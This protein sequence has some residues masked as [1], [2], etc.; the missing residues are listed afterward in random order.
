MTLF[1]WVCVFWGFQKLSNSSNNSYIWY[2]SVKMVPKSELK[3]VNYA[4][5]GK[6]GLDRLSWDA[7]ELD[8]P[9]W[10]AHGSAARV[11]L[12]AGRACGLD[13]SFSS[14][15]FFFLS[16]SLS[17][18][19]LFSF[20][21]SFLFPPLLFLPLPLLRTFF[22][23]FFSS[24]SFIIIFFPSYSFSFPHLCACWISSFLSRT[25]PSSY[26]SKLYLFS[27]TKSRSSSCEPIAIEIGS[28]HG[29]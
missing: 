14:K 27:S 23:P 17:F 5:R 24:S 15:F 9:S 16:L 20:F 21:F 25:R 26:K 6:I 13:P 2:K 29:G 22:F 7:R 19:L 12:S 8:R 4:K 28:T 11:G 18:S 3:W 10:P 1:V